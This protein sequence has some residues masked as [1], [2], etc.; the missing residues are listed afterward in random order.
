MST[1]PGASSNTAFAD[2]PETRVATESLH[3]LATARD[4]SQG[5]DFLVSRLHSGAYPYVEASVSDMRARW[6][7]EAIDLPLSVD[8]ALLAGILS[9]YP[10]FAYALG[11]QAGLRRLVPQLTGRELCAFCI[12]EDGGGHPRAIQ[13]R[14]EAGPSGFQLT[15]RKKFITLGVEAQT[16]LVAASLGW[17]AGQNQ[18]RIVR[19]QADRPGVT[20]TPMPELPVVPEVSHASLS[21]EAVRVAP[22]EVLEGDGYLRYIR[23]FRTVEDIHVSAGMVGQLLQLAW[24]HAWPLP[25]REELLALMQALRALGLGEVTRVA[26]HLSLAGYFTLQDRV[27]ESLEPLVQAL[28]E[29]VRTRW[30]RDQGLRFFAARARGL[31]TEAAWQRL[32]GP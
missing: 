26:T 3:E 9:P 2:T 17:E 15:G 28:P 13:C 4:F 22:E 29:L 32:G 6:M 21:L 23:P 10:A 11:L 5:S 8:Q 16:L 24:T 1:A 20:V 12:T 18:L 14:L 7:A 31:R 19:I 27:F 30:Q 25:V